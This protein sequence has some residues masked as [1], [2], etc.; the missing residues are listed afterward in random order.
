VLAL[1][2]R[3]DLKIKEVLLSV[4][5]SHL[6][7]VSRRSVS[8][9]R[10]YDEVYGIEPHAQRDGRECVCRCNNL[11]SLRFFLSKRGWQRIVCLRVKKEKKLRGFIP[12]ANYTDRAIAAG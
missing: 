4:K 6:Y 9:L 11:S 10:N 8:W 7:K 5:L 12:Q 1:L 2:I 3:R